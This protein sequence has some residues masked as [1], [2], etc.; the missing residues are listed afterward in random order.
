MS[1]DEGVQTARGKVVDGGQTQTPRASTK[2]DKWL[3]VGSTM[4]RRSLAHKSQADL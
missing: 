4:A 3:R 1:L 2:P